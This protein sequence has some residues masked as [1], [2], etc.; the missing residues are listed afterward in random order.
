MQIGI[1]GFTNVGK[2]TFFSA[3]TLVDAEISDRPFTTIKPNI[4][5]GYVT[6]KCVCEELGIKCNPKSGKCVKGIRHIPVKLIDV[7]GLIPDAHKGKGL[8]NQFLSELMQ[9]DAI[10]LVVDVSG[11]VNYE[12]FHIS[13][14]EVVDDIKL[15]E[16]EIDFWIKGILEKHITKLK[17]AY[18]ENALANGIAK[19]VSGLNIK[20]SAVR[21]ALENM[22]D[23]K[24]WREEEFLNF[25]SRL[26]EFG[27]PMLIAANKIDLPNAEKNLEKLKSTYAEKIIVPCCAEAELAL[28]RAAK[29]GLINLSLIHI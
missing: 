7:A 21:K 10:I 18:H 8:G 20:E 2:T 13:G 19:I 29:N 3:A 4:G 28:R 25:A 12:G 17:K 15:L 14:R 9:A 22:P 27:K 24:N 16:R 11:S 23:F 26:R 5:L 6:V 1:A